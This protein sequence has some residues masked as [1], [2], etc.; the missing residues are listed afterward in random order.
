[1]KRLFVGGILASLL[2]GGALSAPNVRTRVLA[3]WSA[4]SGWSPAAR[5]ADPVGYVKWVERRLKRD[6]ERLAPARDELGASVAKLNREKN[7]LDVLHEH[8]RELAVE[9]RDAYHAGEF[10]VTVRGAA[11]T[12][13]Q[14][15]YQ[16]S[17]ALAEADGYANSLD[18]VRDT[19]A[20]AQSQSEVLSV[21][22]AGSHTQLAVL[23]ARRQLLQASQ[24]TTVD[25]TLVA[26]TDALLDGNVNVLAQ[27]EEN[28]VRSVPELLEAGRAA[29][30]QQVA[31][32]NV[33][34]FLSE[35]RALTSPVAATVGGDSKG[36]CEGD[37]AIF[38]QSS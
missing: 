26:Q 11:Y 21:Q 24:L 5:A 30:R 19:I 15:E 34:A 29:S 23:D 36:G 9:F 22:I 31:G 10:P 1:M 27:A 13:Q 6:L 3:H 20:R 25:A 18:I 8:A 37:D 38:R 7:R 16:I 17:L 14:L 28:P 33:R 2:V 4:I 12:K 32:T 35:V